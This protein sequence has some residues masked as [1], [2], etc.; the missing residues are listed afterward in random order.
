VYARYHN[1][2]EVNDPIRERLTALRN[3]L[4][5]LHKILLDSEREIYDHDI[6]RITSAS[7]F[8]GLVLEDPHFAW[9]RELSQL[10]VL[11]DETLD[12][13]EP[14]SGVDAERLIAQ[15][16]SLVTPSEEGTGFAKS[17]YNAM[18]RDPGVVLAHSDMLKV[19]AGLQPTAK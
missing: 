18:Q 11:I 10:V 12:W 15:A 5:K 16:R 9:L 17:Y 13:D 1:T 2:V 7:Q 6:A 8:L 3:G 14:A 19:F 4:L